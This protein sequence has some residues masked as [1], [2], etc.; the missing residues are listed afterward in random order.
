MLKQKIFLNFIFYLIPLLKLDLFICRNLTSGE[1]KLC[2][3]V[4]ENL[5]DYDS[6]Q[7]MNQ[8]FLPWQPSGIIMAPCGAIHLHPTDYRDDFSTQTLA[9]RAI[10]IHEMAHIYQYQQ[11]INVFRHGLILQLGYYLS[12][13]YYNPYHY[14]LKSN[15][16]FFCYN[17]EQQGNIARDIYLGKIKNIIKK[18]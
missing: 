13:K 17:I 5:I 9:E 15:Q 6:V 10:F 18:R 3:S 4:F 11:N 1:I 7:V 2:Q 16:N 14:Q 8:R 12:F